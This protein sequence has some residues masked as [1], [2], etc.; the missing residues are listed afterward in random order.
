MSLFTMMGQKHVNISW[1]NRDHLKRIRHVP[2]YVNYNFYNRHGQYQCLLKSDHVSV[3]GA[4]ILDTTTWHV[5]SFMKLFIIT[6]YISTGQIA[7]STCDRATVTIGNWDWWNEN[8][9]SFIISQNRQ[10]RHQR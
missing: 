5:K 3:S 6:R 1:K 7:L 8:A 2:I 9:F 4:I 10:L